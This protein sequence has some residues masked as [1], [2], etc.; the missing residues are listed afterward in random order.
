[1]QKAAAA[2]IMGVDDLLADPSAGR[3]AKL[4]VIQ[5]LGAVLANRET[6]VAFMSGQAM[7]APKVLGGPSTTGDPDD[8]QDQLDAANAANR[9]LVADRKALEEALH[10]LGMSVLMPGLHYDANSVRTLAAQKRTEIQRAAAAVVGSNDY[11][12]KD[13]VKPVLEEA[14]GLVGNVT[15]DLVGKKVNGQKPITDK[16]DQAIRLVS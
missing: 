5:Q 9:H 1:M 13:A 16:I 2:I 3:P 8:M 4:A 7:K 14:K 6:L 15:A 12:R 10:A 11:V